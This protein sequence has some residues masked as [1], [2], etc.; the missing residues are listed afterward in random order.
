MGKT[1][2]E[3]L[4]LSLPV[5]NAAPDVP[6]TSDDRL[7]LLSPKNAAPSVA[8]GPTAANTW[9]SPGIAAASVQC[10]H[11]L[12]GPISV[13]H[14]AGPYE[15]TAAARKPLVHR[16]PNSSLHL[17]TESQQAAPQGSPTL[18]TLR[19]PDMTSNVTLATKDAFACVNAMF[20]SSLS[21]EPS[22]RSKPVAL[23]EPTVTISTKAAFAELNQ[24]FSSDLPH[25]RQQAPSRQQRTT[26]PPAPRRTIGKRPLLAP[27]KANV[28]ET[29]VGRA[30]TA[31][32]TAMVSDNR[33]MQAE[34][35]DLGMYEDT[36]FLDSPKAAHIGDATADHDPQGFAIYE[37][38]NFFDNQ[39]AG[40]QLKSPAEADCKAAD[41]TGGFQ[42]YEDT[43]CVGQATS[44]AEQDMSPGGLGIYED[45]QFV[46]KA[47]SG[48]PPHEPAG[49][50]AALSPWDFCIREDTQFV[51]KA[52]C[53]D[54]DLKDEAAEASS[55]DVFGSYEDM[56]CKAEATK[57][58]Y[59]ADKV[60]DKENQ[61]ESD[62][63]A[64]ECLAS[65]TCS[66]HTAVS[67]DLICRK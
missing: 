58:A 63:Y 55:P 25:H 36:G 62:K 16:R 20:S 41:A 33:P 64:T 7:I 30:E 8:S 67:F 61:L 34:V 29:E 40:Q 49:S 43:Q 37:D 23:V 27:R 65:W 32:T 26:L 38:T 22:C 5:V 52:A 3:P 11:A 12:L 35:Q 21:H 47:D 18:H 54:A 53:A 46:N 50:N 57:N 66:W 1:A 42:I 10:D 59:A 60:E 15:H 28:S 13:T 44:N 6:S 48:A 51:A 17:S 39:P 4:M 19:L 24:M 31:S 56:L 9:L 14:P 2:L 45:T